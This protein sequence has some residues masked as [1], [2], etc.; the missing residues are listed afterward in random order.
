[1]KTA[2]ELFYPEM[3]VEIGG[4]SFSKG[5]EFDLYS[6]K[7]SYFDWA[8]IRFTKQFKDN[9]VV[10]N[11]DTATIKLGYNGSYETVFQGYVV[12][13][14]DGSNGMNEILLKDAMIFL[15]ETYITKTFLDAAPRDILAYCLGIAGISDF[16]LVKTG[17]SQKKAV[18]IFKKNV[19]EVINLV[20]SLWGIS[21]NFFFMEGTFY[22]GE[23][24]S[25]SKIYTFEYG[26]SIISLNR[27]NSL[28]KL[29]TVS[30]P[31]VKHGHKVVVKHPQVTG[32]FEV[33]KVVFIANDAGFIRTYIYF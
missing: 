14:Y 18:P 33:E 22:W 1:M 4:Y 28:W 15:E 17:Y 29:E 26:S 23:Q 25:Q 10:K 30:V 19:I 12:K 9:I 32:T 3:L 13:T 16:K 6:S 20:H 31:F 8:K 5:I 2:Y 11:K 27:D 21:E 24:P 7:N